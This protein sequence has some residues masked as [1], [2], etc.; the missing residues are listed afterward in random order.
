[1]AAERG[2]AEAQYKLGVRTFNGRGCLQDF[3]VAKKWIQLA[4]NQGFV[5]AQFSL[6][7]MYH[8]GRGVSQ[9]F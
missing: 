3:E 2:H 8:H 9:D 7:L 4:A 6:P 5:Q 1:M